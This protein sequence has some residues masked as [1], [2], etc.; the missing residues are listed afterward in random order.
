MVE[1]KANF[2]N[3][4]GTFNRQIPDQIVYPGFIGWTDG[5]SMF[6]AGSSYVVPEPQLGQNVVLRAVWYTETYSLMLSSFTPLSGSV[7]T[8]VMISG[9]RLAGVER[10]YF[11]NNKL[12]EFTVINDNLIQAVVP[13]GAITG[14]ITLFGPSTSGTKNTNFV[15]I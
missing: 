14:R 12:A 13:S 1:R 9:Q 5:Q 4:G 15:V 8:T 6:Y 11:R 7:G 3:S 2:V 10:V